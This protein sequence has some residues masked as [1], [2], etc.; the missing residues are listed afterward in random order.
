MALEYLLGGV[1]GVTLFIYLLITHPIIFISIAFG[2]ALL[3]ILCTKK[4]DKD[5]IK[6]YYENIEKKITN[7]LDISKEEILYEFGHVKHLKKIK[8]EFQIFTPKGEYLVKPG[9]INIMGNRIVKLEKISDI[10]FFEEINLN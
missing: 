9:D 6:A 4:E 7:N 1:I 2:Y 3:S 8:E 10:N 5:E